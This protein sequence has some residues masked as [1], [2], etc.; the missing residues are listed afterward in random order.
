MVCHVKEIKKMW[1]KIVIGEMYPRLK[2][3]TKHFAC[4]QNILHLL[5]EN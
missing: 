1:L 3:A 5:T 2:K 4:N